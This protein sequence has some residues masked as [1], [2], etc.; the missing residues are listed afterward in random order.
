MEVLVMT[1][2]MDSLFTSQVSVHPV[3]MSMIQSSLLL[4]KYSLLSL[5]LGTEL[6]LLLLGTSTASSSSARGLGTGT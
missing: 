2:S 5:L 6:V 4:V 1:S 3:P